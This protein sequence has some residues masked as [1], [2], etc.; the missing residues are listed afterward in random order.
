MAGLQEQ[1][2]QLRDVLW[3][4]VN[5]ADPEKVAPL[6]KEYRAV[7]ERLEALT[8]AGKVGD[9]IDEIAARRAARGA[10]SGEGA[11]RARRRS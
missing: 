9:P 7:V 3:S 10:G 4:S 2:E 11:R 8:G 5:S 1:L 6:A